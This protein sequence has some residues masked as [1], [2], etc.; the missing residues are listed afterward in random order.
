MGIASALLLLGAE[1]AT[2]A[3]GNA[4]GG[5]SRSNPHSN[6]PY[7]NIIINAFQK[8]DLSFYKME[9]NK[10]FKDLGYRYNGRE[11]DVVHELYIKKFNKLGFPEF[12]VSFLT[13]CI[14]IFGNNGWEEYKYAE[15]SQVILRGKQ[16]GTVDLVFFDNNGKE[17]FVKIFHKYL[18]LN[19]SLL[20]EFADLLNELI[21]RAKGLQV[22]T[23]YEFN[24]DDKMLFTGFVDRYCEFFYDEKEK[25][26]WDA[27][28]NKWNEILLRET[29]VKYFSGSERAKIPDWTKDLFSKNAKHCYA[30][31]DGIIIRK[32]ESNKD[33]K[34][35]TYYYLPELD[36][37]TKKYACCSICR[38]LSKDYKEVCEFDASVSFCFVSGNIKN[39]VT[40]GYFMKESVIK[41]YRNAFSGK[42][43][44]PIQEFTFANFMN[45]LGRNDLS[46]NFLELENKMNVA[47]EAFKVEAKKRHAEEMQKQEEQKKKQEEQK[48]K[49][50]EE[51]I[52]EEKKQEQAKVA[53]LDDF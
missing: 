12:C 48:R 51:R 26:N 14:F 52:L 47:I 1:A 38:P 20:E 15:L 5:G 44:N 35:I 9:E 36:S 32:D 2:R 18:I 21:S 7:A 46:A 50:E 53:V 27:L 16:A 25:Q 22:K 19:S 29:S 49:E 6:N 31:N 11:K 41:F 40:L 4:L 39:K 13:N 24:G 33:A 8:G 30:V 34:D 45:F 43:V 10:R 42:N 23:K 3:L 37:N 17:C 28:L